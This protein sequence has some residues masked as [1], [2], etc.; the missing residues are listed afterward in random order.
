Q[1]SH[2][3]RMAFPLRSLALIV[4]PGPCF[5]LG[6]LPGKLLQRIAQ[7]F[8]APQS[9]VGFG[10]RPTLIHHRRG[11]SQRLQTAG[12]LI[13]LAIVADFWKPAW[14]QALASTRQTR[15]DQ[16]VFMGQKKGVNLLIIV[17][18]LL[19]EWQQ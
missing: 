3:N 19:N 17:S 12:I 10:V 11:A 6:R 13:A 8:D 2:R 1:C 4:L 7:W 16:M 9:A 14:C 18:N 5:A 15:E